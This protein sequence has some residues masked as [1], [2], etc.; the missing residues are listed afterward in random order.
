[1]DRR[2]YF[3][4]FSY[5]KCRTITERSNKLFRKKCPEQ[6]LSKNYQQILC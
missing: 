6:E 2:T 4:K 3:H 5:A 1:M